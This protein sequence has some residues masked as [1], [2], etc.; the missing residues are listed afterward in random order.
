[1]GDDYDYKD[2]YD[3]DLTKF[4]NEDDYY[5][6]LEDDIIIEKNFTEEELENFKNK[7]K[8]YCENLIED[9]F[10][11]NDLSEDELA[12]EICMKLENIS[13]EEYFSE[14]ILED[15]LRTTRLV[16]WIC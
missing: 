5:E 4:G 16:F 12:K 11:I 2:I 15:F 10:Y 14:T 7:V 9:I 13:G 1:M 8:K 6:G 3:F